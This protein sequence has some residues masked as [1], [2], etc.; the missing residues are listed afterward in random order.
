M[1]AQKPRTLLGAVVQQCLSF[2]H[3]RGGAY[4]RAGD[5]SECLSQPRERVDEILEECAARGTLKKHGFKSQYGAGEQFWELE[6]AGALWGNFSLGSNTVDLKHGRRLVGSI[7]RSNIPNLKP[8]ATFTFGGRAWAVTRS[9]REGI[10]IEPAKHASTPCVI[11]FGGSGDDKVTPFFADQL[12]RMITG[13]EPFWRDASV[14]VRERLEKI[15][16]QIRGSCTIA[17]LPWFRTADAYIYFT[18]AGTTLNEALARHLGARVIRN[19]GFC[20]ELDRP[21]SP[22]SFPKDL[23]SMAPI[24]RS[25]FSPSSSQSIFQQLL[26]VQMQEDE[27]VSAHLGDEDATS[28]IQRLSRSE[29]VEI[30]PAHFTFFKSG[31]S[32]N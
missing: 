32:K 27:F 13:T 28:C 18:F 25:L 11:A 5:I 19:N 3:Q 23:L 26:P 15:A 22:L 14:E 12:W 1:P 6:E 10:E 24:F 17:S 21:L 8:G 4:T 7:P 30:S 16:Y 31:V 2:I 20:V 29:L 9:T